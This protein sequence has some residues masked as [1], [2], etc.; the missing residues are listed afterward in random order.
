[1]TK[2]LYSAQAQSLDGSLTWEITI[3]RFRFTITQ[4]RKSIIPIL[5]HI[6]NN[7]DTR[8]MVRTE[9]R[10]LSRL[11]RFLSLTTTAFGKTRAKQERETPT[12]VV[13]HNISPHQAIQFKINARFHPHLSFSPLTHINLEYVVSAFDKKG[14]IITHSDPYQIL[15]PL[16]KHK[17]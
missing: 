5:F 16:P 11:L 3:P 10:S 17:Q 15:I 13:E 2:P 8:L 9:L 4:K 6:K 1:M 14:K 7:S 12:S